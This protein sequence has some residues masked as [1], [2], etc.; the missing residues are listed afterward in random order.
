MLIQTEALFAPLKERIV[1]SYDWSEAEAVAPDDDGVMTATATKTTEQT[2]T[3][4]AAQPPCA[5]VLTV[6]STGTAGDIAAKD[7]V[8]YGTDIN[9]QAISEAITPT[10]D[11]AINATTARA[12][13]TV[14]KIVIGAMD[15]TGANIK[16]GWGDSY[17]LPFVSD[18][19]LLLYSLE[20]GSVATAAT[21]TSNAE[22]SKNIVAF[23]TTS[24]GKT[25]E[26][27]LLS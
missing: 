7:I 2:I 13:K 26:I 1:A 6:K 12:F 5:R 18:G 25:R 14:S 19:E 11:T 4:F 3:E 9:N 22:L 23:H 27:I 20:N 17:G 24:N 16:V 15:G 8:I 21:I 10:A